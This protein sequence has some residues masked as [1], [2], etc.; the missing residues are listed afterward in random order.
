MSLNPP[1]A[2][3]PTAPVVDEEKQKKEQAEKRTKLLQSQ[4]KA[5]KKDAEKKIVGY[6]SNQCNDR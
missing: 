3:A 4:L 1:A 5:L 2:P 6:C